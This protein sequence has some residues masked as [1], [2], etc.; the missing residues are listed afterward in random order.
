[1]SFFKSYWLLISVAF[2]SFTTVMMANAVEY[3]ITI[4]NNS[5]QAL[6]VSLAN[7]NAFGS[8]KILISSKKLDPLRSIESSAQITDADFIELSAKNIKDGTPL[9]I[10]AQKSWLSAKGDFEFF[11]NSKSVKKWVT[12]TYLKTSKNEPEIAI[13]LHNHKESKDALEALTALQNRKLQVRTQKAPDIGVNFELLLEIKPDSIQKKIFDLAKEKKYEEIDKLVGAIT[14]LKT[15]K[16]LI[17]F[18]YTIALILANQIRFD[19]QETEAFLRKPEQTV[20]KIDAKK[21][22]EREKIQWLYIFLEEKDELSGIGTVAWL[23]GPLELIHDFFVDLGSL[24]EE[25][26]KAQTVQD[27]QKIV[28]NNFQQLFDKLFMTMAIEPGLLPQLDALKKAMNI[29]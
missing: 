12:P 8:N 23:N 25:Y 19:A 27:V 4:H 15:L 5:D 26:V 9:H 13:Y 22:A 18:Q 16:E 14:D 24:Q 7:P 17:A 3:A 20:I 2:F 11:I 21:L 6:Q 28:A 10:V 29:K 1:M